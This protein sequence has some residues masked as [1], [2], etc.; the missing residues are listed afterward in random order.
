VPSRFALGNT[1]ALN[2]VCRSRDQDANLHLA[3]CRV[4]AIGG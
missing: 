2:S 4:K 3:R 1:I